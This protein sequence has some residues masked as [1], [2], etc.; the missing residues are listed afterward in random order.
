MGPSEARDG[1]AGDDDAV[2]LNLRIWGLSDPKQGQRADA[3]VRLAIGP[4]PVDSLRGMR[5]SARNKLSATAI[6]KASDVILGVS[7]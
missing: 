6:V 5:L 1:R 3:S 2:H 7:D 4:G